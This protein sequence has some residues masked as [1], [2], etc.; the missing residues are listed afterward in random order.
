MEK[1]FAYNH[2]MEFT[3]IR[4]IESTFTILRKGVQNVVEY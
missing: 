2:V 4:A 1:A 3:S